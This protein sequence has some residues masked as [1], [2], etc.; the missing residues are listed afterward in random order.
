MPRRLR[1][2]Y[3]KTQGESVP[4]RRAEPLRLTVDGEVFDVREES[5]QP[6]ACYYMWTS[7]PNPGYGFTSVWS[8]GH[9]S[10]MREHETAIRDFLTSINPETGYL[11]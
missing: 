10:S 1:P 9:P 2:T 11:D 5:E 4:S 8:D 3:P 6:G 7:G